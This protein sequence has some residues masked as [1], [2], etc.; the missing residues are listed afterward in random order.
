M[1][2]PKWLTTFGLGCLVYL[3]GVLAA[4]LFG[5]SHQDDDGTSFMYA[6]FLTFPWFFLA[7]YLPRLLFGAV[8][9]FHDS[10]LILLAAV[11]N[12]IVVVGIRRIV[13]GS[14]AL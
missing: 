14:N 10:P 2:R 7:T 4:Y 9:T 11:I 5:L 6:A 13:R 3:L 1:T 8:T 12:V